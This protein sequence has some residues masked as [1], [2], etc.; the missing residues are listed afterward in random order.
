[1]ITL[2][3][4]QF[5]TNNYYSLIIIQ[6]QNGTT[7]NLENNLIQGIS[8]NSNISSTNYYSTMSVYGSTNYLSANNFTNLMIIPLKL[9]NAQNT[10]IQKCNFNN[11]YI[12]NGDILQISSYS[13]NTIAISNSTFDSNLAIQGD[14]LNIYCQGSGLVQFD[15]LIMTNNIANSSGILRINSNGN[16]NT[17]AISNST[18]DSN[19]AI[20][21]SLF[22][23][24]YRG[25]VLI[26]DGLIITNNTANLGSILLITLD[27][28]Q[29][30]LKISNSFFYSN[31]YFG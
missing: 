22:Y 2:S 25:S 31:I 3:N 4:S 27:S 16:N 21:G 19:S 30:N 28:N 23:I 9:N 13:D 18:F 7:F 11:N 15:G 26:F 8:E 29:I 12:T 20:Q 1:M 24:Y 6:G 17:I 10:T 14:V 5:Y